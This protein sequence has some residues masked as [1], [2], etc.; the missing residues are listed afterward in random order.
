M[1][2]TPREA[3]AM[4]SAMR[5]RRNAILQREHELELLLC[6]GVQLPEALTV[7]NQTHPNPKEF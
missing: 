4:Q 6:A 2:L 7:V 1:L 3:S 5:R